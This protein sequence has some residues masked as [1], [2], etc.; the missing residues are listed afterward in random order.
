MNMKLVQLK[1]KCRRTRPLTST[2][3]VVLSIIAIIT[4]IVSCSKDQAAEPNPE[5]SPESVTVEN[6]SYINFARALFESKCSSCHAAG[7]SASGK[8]TFS[9]YTSVKNNAATIKNVVLE[10]RTMPLGGSLTSQERELL[11][12]WFTRNTPEN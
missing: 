4:A 8:W 10:N 7:A 12:A 6:V 9:G 1:N 11:A 2:N 3:I 5:P